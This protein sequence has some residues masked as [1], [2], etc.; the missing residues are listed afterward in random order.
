MRYIIEYLLVFFS[1]TG[2]FIITQLNR[3]F[4]HVPNLI[5]ASFIVDSEGWYRVSQSPSLLISGSGGWP[6]R[7]GLLS[8][9]ARQ[10]WDNREVD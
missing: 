3:R 5:Q 8:P 6:Q 10:N 7:K 9:A 4:P 2:H 1:N